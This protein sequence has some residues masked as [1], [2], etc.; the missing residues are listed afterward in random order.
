MNHL[1]AKYKIYIICLI[2]VVLVAAMFL[3]G[4]KII[5]HSNTVLVSSFADQ[6]HKLAVL[7]AEEQ[8]YKQ[9]T[10]DLTKVQ[11]EKYQPD[12][13]FSKDTTLVNE[14]QTLEALATTTNVTMTVNGLSGTVKSAQVAPTKSTIFQIPYGIALTGTLDNC[15]AF[16]EGIEH[17]KFVTVSRSLSLNA[18][19]SGNV[20]INLSAYFYLRPQ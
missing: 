14:L 18:A 8:S 7:Q 16:L 10:S 19:D 20:A 2:W 6:Q 3:Y 13:L 11:N 17:L 5:D 15:L 1:K 12:D 4:F 9:A